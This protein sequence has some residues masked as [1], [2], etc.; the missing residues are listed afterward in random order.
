M[1]R[2]APVMKLDASEA[3]KTAAGPSSTGSPQRPSG[4]FASMVARAVGSFRR[5]VLISVA[6]GPGQSALTL[7]PSRAHSSARVLV[8]SV[9]PPLTRRIRGAPGERDL[10]E[11][12]RDV[13]HP[14]PLLPTHRLG[15]SATAE[16]GAFQVR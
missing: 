9:R 3:R 12:A 1:N 7:I 2:V 5:G 8:R 10:A 6:K 15:D 14:A 13:D 4:I 11:H 16:P